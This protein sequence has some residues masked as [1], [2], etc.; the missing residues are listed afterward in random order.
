[1]EDLKHKLECEDD[2]YNEELF[3]FARPWLEIALQDAYSAFK[4]D[5]VFQEMKKKIEQ[6]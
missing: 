2:P 1:M 4:E 6:E 3:E 5:V